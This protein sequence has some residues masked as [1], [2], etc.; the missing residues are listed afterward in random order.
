MSANDAKIKDLLAVIEK[1]HTQ[2]GPKPR[3]SLKTNGL[4]K[5]DDK[6]ININ[7]INTLDECIR[8]IASINQ[9][10]ESYVKAAKL[11]GIEDVE[12]PKINGFSIEEWI[13][14][15]KLKVAIIKW[16]V[17]DKNIKALELKLK[18]LRSEDLKTA[19][20]L[21]EISSLL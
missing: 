14:D 11:L 6:S 19:D 7:T 10:H 8:A 9:V 15:F 2:L 21:N 16:T 5:Q 1:K 17:E 18:D 20:A 13:D 4:L 12:M 3:M